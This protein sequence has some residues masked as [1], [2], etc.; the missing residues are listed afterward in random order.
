LDFEGC[1]AEPFWM[2][3]FVPG[4]SLVDNV[5]SLTR[6]LWG[7]PYAEW[8][9]CLARDLIA[10][11]VAADG[12][13]RREWAAAILWAVALDAGMDRDADLW[14]RVLV[15]ITTSTGVAEEC[16]RER[17]DQLRDLGLARPRNPPLY[18]TK[19]EPQDG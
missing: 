8:A 13:E 18:W 12:A 4:R 9:M 2:A 7:K 10:E 3:S 17:F 5:F 16:A 11:R 1:D 19:S 6:P 15:D 14:R